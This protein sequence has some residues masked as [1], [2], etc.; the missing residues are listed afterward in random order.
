M[1]GATA[2]TA[3]T[4][5]IRLD[6]PAPA[7]LDVA[8]KE[9][10]LVAPFVVTSQ[11][12]EGR[13]SGS[14]LDVQEA[15]GRYLER[16][17]RR[18]TDLTLVQSTGLRY[19]TFELE[20]L[21][22]DTDFWSAVGERASADLILVGAVDFDVRDRSGYLVEEYPSPVDG[23]TMYR[24]VLVEQTGFELDIVLVVIDGS[25]GELLL[26]DNVKDWKT[27]DRG[28]A[29]PRQGLFENLSSTEQRIAGLFAP[30]GMQVA[31]LLLLD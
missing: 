26:S 9:T 29:N 7:Q 1:T 27:F 22:R 12:G 21:A 15:L 3:Q 18:E 11:E 2:A 6:L 28:V 17:V 31:R 24:Q 23:S 19:P 10:L 5:E 13:V 8:E 16:V 14:D 25:T 4:V 30:Q 20:V